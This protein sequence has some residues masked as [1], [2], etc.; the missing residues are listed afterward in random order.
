MRLALL[1]D[2]R[3]ETSEMKQNIAPLFDKG[4]GEGDGTNEGWRLG[5]CS[6]AGR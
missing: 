5:V 6:A 4:N 3:S 1:A 2:E